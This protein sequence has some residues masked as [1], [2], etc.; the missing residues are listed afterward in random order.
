MTTAPYDVPPTA[1]GAVVEEG[2]GRLPFVLIHGEALVTAAVWALGE[3]GV[4][5]VDLGT[6]WAGIQASEEPLV[7]HDAL[8]PMTPP[9]FIAACLARSVA[10][11]AVV[12]GVRA[13]TDT[14]KVLEG[15]RLG[16]TVD[17]AGLVTVCSPVVL[18]AAVV[19]ELDTLPATDFTAL[20]EALESR[21][22]VERVEAP[23][24]ARRVS[25]DDD[26]AVLA[27][28]TEPIR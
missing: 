4:T 26:V 2:R 12:V 11:G 10:T 7:L 18:P 16:E 3:S 23:P 13:V 28:L 25:S 27:A 21:F 8:C 14:V 6:G 20:V 5:P 22:P 19:A 15:D 24:E 17:R 9:G 1:L